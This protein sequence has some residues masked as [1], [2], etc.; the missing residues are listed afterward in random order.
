MSGKNKIIDVKDLSKTFRLKQKGSGL[1]A[2]VTSLFNPKYKEVKAVDKVSFSVNEGELLAF[3]G[4]NGAGKSTTIKM[5][6]GILF[7]TSGEI[8]IMGFDPA[9]QRQDLAYHVGSVF[10][11]KPQLW[12]H[13][14][15]QDTYNLFSRIY[16]IDQK[17]YKK[18]LDYLVKAFDI[19]DLLQTPVRKLSLGQRMRCEIVAS[20][21]HEPK[22][23]FL[24]EPTIGLDVIAK[25][26]IR[27]VIKYLNQEEKVTIFLT[28]HDV[29]DIETLAN[30]AIVINNGQI[31]FD[32]KTWRLKQDHLKKKVVEIIVADSIKGF[33]ESFGEVVAK[34][35]RSIKFELDIKEG[36]VDKLLG[37][38]VNNYGIKDINIYDQ[39]M[40]EIIADI[41]RSK[42]T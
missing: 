11:Q 9:K 37:Y 16:E 20:L 10:G 24:D 40:E 2:G 1:L 8:D 36:V 32:D 28:S 26:S 38:A 35:K 4:P 14:S 3:I 13:L 39:P 33:D 19:A 30:R 22:I 7:P 27:E 31:I 41:Y 12:Y 18:R 5:L 6:T 15:P 42:K 21:I 34:T 23:V 17:R 29:G 25:Q